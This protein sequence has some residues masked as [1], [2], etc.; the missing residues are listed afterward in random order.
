MTQIIERRG[1]DFRTHSPEGKKTIAEATAMAW[2]NQINSDTPIL[3]EE[4]NPDVVNRKRSLD[5]T[6]KKSGRS[7]CLMFFAQKCGPCCRNIDHIPELADFDLEM[8]S[9]FI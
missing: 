2:S 1:T 4:G 3:D 5:G 8:E 7:D 6:R 9:V